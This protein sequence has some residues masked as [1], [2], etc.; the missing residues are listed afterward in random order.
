MSMY[1]KWLNKRSLYKKDPQ[2]TGVVE[3][4][5]QILYND[6]ANNKIT[7]LSTGNNSSVSSVNKPTAAVKTSHLTLKRSLENFQSIPSLER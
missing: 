6:A 7:C 3:S 4:K 2:Q 5:S 1:E